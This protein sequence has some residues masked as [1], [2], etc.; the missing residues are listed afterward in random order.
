MNEII[1]LACEALEIDRQTLTTSRK[2]S[3]VRAR[4]LI[5]LVLR[6]EGY[7]FEAISE[8]LGWESGHSPGQY[9]VM[10]AKKQVE[11]SVFFRVQLNRVEQRLRGVG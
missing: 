2:R 7:G 4:H 3:V 10:Q 5:A 1:T 9:A 11:A 6:N 8:K